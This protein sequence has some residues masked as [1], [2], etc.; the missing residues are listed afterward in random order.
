MLRYKIKHYCVLVARDSAANQGRF[1][2]LVSVSLQTY[3]C[4]PGNFQCQL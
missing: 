2:I 4:I 3:G 1:Q